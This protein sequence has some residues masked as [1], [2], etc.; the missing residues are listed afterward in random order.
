MKADPPQ[1]RIAQ[2]TVEPNTPAPSPSPPE[3]AGFMA[4]WPR[5]AQISLAVV[6]VLA[7]VLIGWRA[8]GMQRWGARPTELDP[9]SPKF[10]RLDLNRADHVQLLQLPDVG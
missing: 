2:S 4:A 9:T 1:L 3:P 10:L 5:S 7:V 6:L 8:Y